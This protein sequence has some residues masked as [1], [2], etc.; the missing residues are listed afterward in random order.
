[1]RNGLQF[2]VDELLRH[3]EASLA[4]GATAAAALSHQDFFL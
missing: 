4:A 3:E 2:S 1:M